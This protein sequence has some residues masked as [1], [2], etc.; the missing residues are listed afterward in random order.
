MKKYPKTIIIRN[1]GQLSWPAIQ[2]IFTGHSTVVN[3]VA[4]SP[5]GGR[6]VSGWDDK[7]VRIRDAETGELVIQPFQG[8]QHS[9]WSVAFSPDGRRLAIRSK[10]ISIQSKNGPNIIDSFTVEQDGWILG[11]QSELLLWVPPTLRTGLHGLRN[12]LSIGRCVKTL[13]DFGHFAHGDEWT[14]CGESIG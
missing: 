5:D 3:C 13:L 9:V 2:K 12:T 1:G 7:T 6:V 4:F 8:H 14:R 11:P 10:F